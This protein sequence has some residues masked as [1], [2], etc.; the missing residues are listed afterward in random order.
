MKSLQK[1]ILPLLVLA[2]IAVIYF[3]YF[4]PK[5]E[6]GLFSAFDTNNSANKE[7][8][9][10]I[11]QSKEIVEDQANGITTFYGVDKSGVE[12]LVQAPFI[13]AAELSK[14]TTIKLSG[15]LHADHFHASEILD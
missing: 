4:A 9:I 12:F 1:L 13:S 10:G 8:L 6:L 11:V 15:H 14:R 3:L 5:D 2:V 7:I